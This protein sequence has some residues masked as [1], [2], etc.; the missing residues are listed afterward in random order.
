MAKFV[1]PDELKQ[2]IAE[3]GDVGDSDFVIH[4][5]TTGE[6]AHD[7]IIIFSSCGM[8]QRAAISKELYADGTYR[9]IS[10]LF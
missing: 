2:T 1:I 6:D 7:R 8:R 9:T 3:H 5:S 4:N 10:N